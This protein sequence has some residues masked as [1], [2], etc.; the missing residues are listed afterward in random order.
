VAN[1]HAHSA[2]YWIASA[3][4]QFYGTPGGEVGSIGVIKIHEDISG[5]LEQHG[6]NVTVIAHPKHKAEGNPFQPLDDDALAHHR[7]QVQ[8]T[9]DEF[10]GEVAR[11]R[12]VTRK[13][14]AADFGQGRSFHSAV[15]TE[16]GMLDGVKT[17]PS[18][19]SRMGEGSGKASITQAESLREN[20]LLVKSWE[21][22]A[23]ILDDAPHVSIKLKRRS[24]DLDRKFRKA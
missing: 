21:T 9:Y 10:E 16:A 23:V 15:A 11:N 5:A 6:V 14:V 13:R 8:A 4:D 24:L 12:G 1:S 3:A 22:C 17:L 2:A 20:E 7:G 18:V 19:L